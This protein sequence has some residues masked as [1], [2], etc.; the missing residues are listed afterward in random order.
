MTDTRHS[1]AG[2]KAFKLA[3]VSALVILVVF[4]MVIL[5]S[6]LP[7]LRTGNIIGI[8]TSREVLFAIGLS[9]ATATA[10]TIIA[11]IVAVPAAYAL[12]HSR[13]AGKDIVDTILDL[14]IVVSP[15]AM[16][17]ALLAFFNTSLGSAIQDHLMTFVFTVAG[18]VLAQFTIVS[19]LAIRLLKATFDGIEPRYEHVARTLGYSQTKAF[20]KVTLPLAG[21]GLLAATALVWA[22]AIGEFG[23]TVTLAG[24]TPLKTE[25]MPIAIFL[26]L[27]SANLEKTVVIIFVLIAIAVIS[28]LAI[29]KLGRRSAY[30]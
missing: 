10:A 30:Q 15:I 6:L 13:F 29:R 26:S 21:R 9:L 28:L 24:A 19:A 2:G 3:T 16:G 11:L 7:W 14:P 23:A 5:L 12:S 25:T 18:I 4:F 8:L 17:A 1:L 22:R 27:A 20:M